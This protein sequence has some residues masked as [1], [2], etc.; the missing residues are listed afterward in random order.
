MPGWLFACAYGFAW[1][2]V[3]PWVAHVTAPFIYS[4]F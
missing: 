3:L 4:Q 2:M 1:A